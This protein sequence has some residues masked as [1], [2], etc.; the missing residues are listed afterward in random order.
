MPMIA[1]GPGLIGVYR[2]RNER[3]VVDLRRSAVRYGFAT[4]VIDAPVNL[5]AT[6]LRFPST[7]EWFKHCHN[8]NLVTV[9]LETGGRSR[10]LGGFHHPVRPAYVLGDDNGTLPDDLLDLVRYVVRVDT[11]NPGT[12]YN[13]VV[14]ALVLNDRYTQHKESSVCA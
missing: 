10:P 3:A 5:A 7:A 6:P 4:F 11:P 9:A 1:P 12:L 8:H 13:A 14:G 2:P